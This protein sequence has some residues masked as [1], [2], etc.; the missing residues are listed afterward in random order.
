LREPSDPAATDRGMA[1]ARRRDIQSAS[2]AT[3]PA[4]RLAS[5]G[6]LWYQGVILAGP[7]PSSAT[8]RDAE[9]CWERPEDAAG[10]SAS[11]AG[12]VELLSSASF[13]GCSGS[14]RRL[15]G[16][17]TVNRALLVCGTLPACTAC[18]GS[19]SLP[20]SVSFVTQE[21]RS[22]GPSHACGAPRPSGILGRTETGNCPPSS[23]LPFASSSS[24]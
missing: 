23:Y 12:A 3:R 18:F 14:Q 22:I 24:A 15:P 16:S 1:S 13:S 9:R 2:R 7:R 17:G 5:V 6:P 11:P 20:G 21:S 8:P 4:S 19:P 10:P